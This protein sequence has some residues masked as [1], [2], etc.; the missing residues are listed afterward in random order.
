MTSVN[1]LLESIESRGVDP[2]I[3]EVIAAL[4]CLRLVKGLTAHE[5]DADTAVLLVGWAF[6]IGFD[7]AEAI[8]REQKAAEDRAEAEELATHVIAFSRPLAV[9]A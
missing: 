3:A 1:S 6:R 8:K 9:P 5:V 7:C 4:D 2:A